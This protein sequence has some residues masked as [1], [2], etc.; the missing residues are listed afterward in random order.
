MP[1]SLNRIE[2]Y[3]VGDVGCLFV[4][5]GEVDVDVEAAVVLGV[6][7]VNDGGVIIFNIYG[8]VRMCC[9]L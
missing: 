3:A 2:G 1:F 4:V 7:G 6:I 5:V 9:G 8:V